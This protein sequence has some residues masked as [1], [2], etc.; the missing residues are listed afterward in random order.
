MTSISSG[1][2]FHNS[3]L[4]VSVPIHSFYSLSVYTICPFIAGQG[5]TDLKGF[6]PT[7]LV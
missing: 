2:V 7:N 6:I 1:D 5:V 4:Y 3:Y